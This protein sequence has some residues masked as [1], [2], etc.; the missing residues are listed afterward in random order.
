ME[1]LTVV[2][3]AGVEVQVQDGTTLGGYW[4]RSASGS[5]GVHSPLCIRCM[6]V[7]SAAGVGRG[8]IATMDVVGLDVKTG[9]NLRSRIAA[10]CGL[11][12]ESSVF[13]NCSHTHSGPQTHRG[14]VGMGHVSEK[15]MA[16]FLQS[17]VD[18][19]RVAMEN[20]RKVGQCKYY[21]VP[22]ESLSVNRRQRASATS[23][24]AGTRWFEVAGDTKMGT[25]PGGPKVQHAHILCFYA[26]DHWL[27]TI[28][29]YAC[30][31][32]C[33]GPGMCQSSGFCGE[34]RKVVEG[35]MADV[36]NGPSG[37][38]LYLQGACGDVNPVERKGGYEAATRMGKTL[39]RLIV[40]NMTAS[41]PT[42]VYDTSVKFDVQMSSVEVK[43]PLQPLPSRDEA[44][45]FVKQQKCWMEEAP[46]ELTPR[47]CHIYA[48]HIL[49]VV[50]EGIPSEPWVASVVQM[51]N[52]GRHICILGFEAELFCEYALDFEM[53]SAFDATLVCGYS[54]RGTLGYIF[55]EAEYPKGGYEVVHAFRVYG[56]LQNFA[57]TVERPLVTAAVNLMRRSREGNQLY[58]HVFDSKFTQAHDTYNGIGISTTSGGDIFYVLSS[59]DP[60][61]SAKVYKYSVASSCV[62]P[63]CCLGEACDDPKDLVAQGKSH[64]PFVED[65]KTGHL[66]FAS[67]VG[68]YNYTDGMETLPKI[69]PDGLGEYPGGCVLSLDPKTCETK[70]H[71]RD[72]DGEGILAFAR[73]VERGISYA[74][75]WP[76][77][78]FTVVDASGSSKLDY[79]GRGNG[80]AV[81]PRTGEYRCIC[82]ALIVEPSTGAVFW[83]NAEGDV[84]VYRGSGVEVALSGEEGMRRDYFGTYDYKSPG[85]MAYNWRQVVLYQSKIVG[86]HGNSGYL[87]QLDP[88]KLHL[89]IIDRITSLPSKRCGFYDQFSYGY[90]GFAVGRQQYRHTVFYLTGAPLYDS[91]GLRLRG[92]ESTSKGESKGEEELRLVT[93]DLQ[94]GLYTDHGRIVFANRLGWPKYVNSLVVGNDG[95]IYALSRLPSGLTDLIR[96]PIPELP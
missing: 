22:I 18:C 15:F 54:G 85:T 20:R 68:Y 16:T 88:L 31:P 90:L 47:Q 11:G 24:T 37:M 21:R 8:V 26:G 72:G 27:G 12:S 49:R 2:G 78:Y 82:R 40:D 25:R 35:Y 96:I 46:D 76:C 4:G 92:K 33:T 13:L 62:E 80:E 45:E 87:F 42:R 55:T 63:V 75:T 14:F 5:N 84:L 7:E 91:T 39:G 81:H 28:L 94:R 58:A 17:V 89:E 71:Y 23:A 48:Q 74:L 36:N 19:S 93:Y 3:V 50:E 73:D 65:P 83:T 66:W 64:V 38:C 43:L 6:Y 60:G 95:H 41:P 57:P 86:V 1:V 10:A 34:A 61:V 70:V 51:L 52:L 32:T 79:K 9:S 69:V 44:A 67:H 29:Q 53:K 59:E 56:N 30:H 77:G